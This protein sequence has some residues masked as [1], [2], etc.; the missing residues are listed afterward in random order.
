MIW[1][2]RRTESL[3]DHPESPVLG[4]V[5][6]IHEGRLVGWAVSRLSASTRL[7]ILIETTAKKFTA[8]RADRYRA[9]V[10]RA[11]YSRDGYC[12][13]VFP[14]SR[15]AWTGPIRILVQDYAEELPGSPVV[16]ADP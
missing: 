13:F 5:E 8:V 2:W 14:V 7:T 11:G 6:G 10:H 1:P 4:L 16:K 12:G 3:F 9:D 15:L